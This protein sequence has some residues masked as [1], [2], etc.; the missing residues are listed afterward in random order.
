MI[1]D[2]DD[3]FSLFLRTYQRRRIILTLFRQD[4]ELM[5]PEW[6]E[7]PTLFNQHWTA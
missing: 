3:R 4:N 6:E 5:I 1:V 7:A 2:F